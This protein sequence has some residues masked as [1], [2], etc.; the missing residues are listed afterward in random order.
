[1]EEDIPM[2]QCLLIVSMHRTGT[3][4]LAG[5]LHHCG[6]RAGK[7]LLERGEDNRKGFFEDRGIVEFNEKVL[8]AI[9]SSWDDIYWY[10]QKLSDATV[11]RFL[12][13]LEQLVAGLYEGTDRCVIKDPRITLLYPLYRRALER[14]GIETHVVMTLRHPAEVALS[15]AKRNRF[16]FEKGLLLWCRYMLQAETSTRESNRI[17][18]RYD[19]LLDAP[20]EILARLS[21]VF[22][23]EY[24]ESLLPEGF[25]DPGMKHCHHGQH[26]QKR[27]LEQFADTLFSS[28]ASRLSDGTEQAETLYH[29]HLLEYAHRFCTVEEQVDA[30]AVESGIGEDDV[31]G[32]LSALSAAFGTC[33]RGYALSASTAEA[34]IRKTYPLDS[35]RLPTDR[36]LRTLAD[37]LVSAIGV[38]ES[39]ADK[40]VAIAGCDA[41]GALF[42]SWLPEP[43]VVG[44]ADAAGSGTEFCGRP[45]MTPEALKARGATHLLVTP[46]FGDMPVAEGFRTVS[47]ETGRCIEDARRLSEIFQAVAPDRLFYGIGRA[48]VARMLQLMAHEEVWIY[49]AGTIGRMAQYFLGERCRGVIDANAPSIARAFAGIPVV[50][51]EAHRF[52]RG[53]KIVMTPLGREDEIATRL[54]E[55]DPEAEPIVLLPDVPDGVLYDFARSVSVIFEKSRAWEDDVLK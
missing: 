45:V 12:P 9:G 36:P 13:E 21:G 8:A 37:W 41:F 27:E 53:A 33:R 24:S 54:R 29:R 5:L 43:C 47:V 1:M 48:L 20:E 44:F 42:A 11:E 18:V 40:R 3:S 46:D 19:H 6:F 49:G 38:L 4:A 22:G 14:Q 50:L 2:K 16:T 39:V 23:L 31:G 34:L 52:G 32:R 17:A 15:L 35:E 10:P 25:I 26:Y 55:L 28:L 7:E 30:L 51:P